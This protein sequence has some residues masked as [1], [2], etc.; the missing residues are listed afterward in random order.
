LAALLLVFA[1]SVVSRYHG[2][3][4]FADGLIY[5]MLLAIALHTVFFAWVVS[6]VGS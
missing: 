4:R 5:S 1:G 6:E 3:P 2:Y